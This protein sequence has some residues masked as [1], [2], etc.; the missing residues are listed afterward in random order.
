[1]KHT[2]M[3]QKSQLTINLEAISRKYQRVLKVKSRVKTC[4]VRGIWSQQLEY[5]QVPKKRDGTTCP[6]G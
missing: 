4:Q 6:E 2:E 5:K 3:I 1:M